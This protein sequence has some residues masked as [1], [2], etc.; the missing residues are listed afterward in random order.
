MGGVQNKMAPK[1]K[2][3]VKFRKKQTWERQIDIL[4]CCW[5]RLRKAFCGMTHHFVALTSLRSDVRGKHLAGSI[6]GSQCWLR[7]KLPRIYKPNGSTGTLYLSVQTLRVLDWKRIVDM[8]RFKKKCHTVIIFP[9]GRKV[10]K[11]RS[12]LKTNNFPKQV[13]ISHRI[14]YLPTYIWLISKVNIPIP[15]ESVMDY[16]H[17]TASPTLYRKAKRASPTKSSSV[18]SVPWRQ[19]EL[20]KQGIQPKMIQNVRFIDQTHPCQGKGDLFLKDVRLG[21]I[22]SPETNILVAPENRWYY[23]RNQSYSNHPFSAAMSC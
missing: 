9:K 20:V 10:I 17:P 5:K 16:D 21:M 1:F 13:F 6:F 7:T 14:Q 12:F 18:I 11:S 23:K 3:A 22:P 15:W 4:F 19:N 8:H 2:K